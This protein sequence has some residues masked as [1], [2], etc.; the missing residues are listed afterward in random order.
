MMLDRAAFMQ[1]AL[2]GEIDRTGLFES[3]VVAQ[4]DALAVGS[5]GGAE[6]FSIFKNA[7]HPGLAV[8]LGLALVLSIQR[9]RRLSKIVWS[10]VGAI[11]V[12]VVNRVSR[13]FAVLKNPCDVMR[14]QLESI[15]VVNSDVPARP[16]P[17]G[18]STSLDAASHSDI[19]A[20]ANAPQI[21]E[22]KSLPQFS[23]RHVPWFHCAHSS[24]FKA[25]G[26]V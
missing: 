10:I 20:P 21:I 4:K 13:E 8:R 24:D 19:V 9:A 23:C 5:Y 6:A 3:R 26:R 25:I 2:G 15:F 12:Y 16:K 17:T 7:E 22:A 11:T 14:Q 1:S 18:G